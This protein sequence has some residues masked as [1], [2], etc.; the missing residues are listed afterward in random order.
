MIAANS[1][2]LVSVL[3]LTRNEEIHIRRCVEVSKK[4]SNNIF[5]ID[6]NSSDKTSEIAKAMGVD[7]INGDFNLFADKFNWAVACIKFPTPWIFRLDADEILD[8]TTIEMLHCFLKKVP[9]SIGGVY[10][11]RQLWF[12]GRWIRHGGIY[13]TYS[14]RLFRNGCVRSEQR[15][16][17]EHIIVLE[18]ASTYL[19]LD[20]IDNPLISLTRWI[21]KHNQYSTLEVEQI[22]QRTSF[23]NPL[24]LK[25][26][27]F[28]NRLSRIRWVK[29]NIFY[30]MPF[31]LRPFLYFFYRY[32]F[33]CGFLDGKEGFLFHFFHAFWYRM[34]VDGKLY[35]SKKILAKENNCT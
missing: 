13:P 8:N 12:M 14:L 24:K 6:S 31:F 21:E 15:K 2:N 27:L 4:I 34:L 35:E 1:K 17:D 19:N 25:A 3:I 30:R 5:I 9:D 33:R 16:L 10:L 26:S 29:Q 28:G 20:V 23:Q 18:G 7:V 32:F 11:R 22:I